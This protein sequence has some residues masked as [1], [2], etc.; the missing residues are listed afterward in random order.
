MMV[1]LTINNKDIE[2]PEGSTILEVARQHGID[3][4]TLCYH[5]ALEP[6]GVCRL[7]LVEVSGA[8]RRGLRISCVQN[9]VDGLIVETHSDRVRK[10]RQF[11]FELLLARSPDSNQLVDLAASHGVYESRFYIGDTNDNCVRWISSK[12][13]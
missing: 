2:A 6:F 11:L 13:T 7:C 4:P 8:L 5:E 12:F 1:Q 10:N 9:V 3:I